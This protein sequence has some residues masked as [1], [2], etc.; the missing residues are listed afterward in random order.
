MAVVYEGADVL[1]RVHP[2]TREAELETRVEELR[3]EDPVFA[4]PRVRHWSPGRSM[5][6]PGLEPGTP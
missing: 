4:V 6:R 5:A 3:L 1:V 2:Q